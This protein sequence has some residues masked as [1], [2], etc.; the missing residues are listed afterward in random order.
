VRQTFVGGFAPCFEERH[1][2]A[3]PAVA[4]GDGHVTLEPPKSRP[5]H[6]RAVEVFLELDSSSESQPVERRVHQLRTR[7]KAPGPWSPA[8]CGSR[9]KPP[10][11]CRSRRPAAPCP[12]STPAQ[13]LR[14]VRWSG[15][16]Y[17]W[18]HPSGTEQSARRSGRPPGSGGQ[19]PQR[20]G[21]VNAWDTLASSISREV[22]STARNP[23]DPSFGWIRQVFLPVQ[24]KPAAV[25]SARSTTG[26]VV[27]KSACHEG[28]ELLAQTQLQLFSCA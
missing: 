11:R 22:S 10:G 26:P 4:H 13:S 16:K 1:K 2:T 9:G 6:R 18:P 25:A 7:L 5:P 8:L 23:Y 24:P 20:S 15:K 28:A 17:I 14:D 19:L 27:H 3:H 12:P 21:T